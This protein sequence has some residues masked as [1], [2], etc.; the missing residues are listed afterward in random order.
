MGKRKQKNNSQQNH[1]NNS[2]MNQ[3]KGKRQKRGGQKKGGAERCWIENCM[4]S[5]QPNLT[6]NCDMAVFLSR[7]E[8]VDGHNPS[9]EIVPSSDLPPS[10]IDH[11]D[12]AKSVP[13]ISSPITGHTIET[14]THGTDKICDNNSVVISRTKDEKDNMTLSKTMAEKSTE[15]LVHNNRKSCNSLES[16]T[17]TSAKTAGVEDAINILRLKAQKLIPKRRRQKK[18]ISHVVKIKRILIELKLMMMTKLTRRPLRRRWR[19]CLKI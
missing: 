19:K 12:D 7:V 16:V 2:Q 5:R 1:K 14:T 11:G 17:A 15:G 9:G 10:K 13:T 4:E 18:L 3:S 8:L 6:K